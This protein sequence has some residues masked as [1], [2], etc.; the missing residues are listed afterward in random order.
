MATPVPTLSSAGWVVTPAQKADYLMAHFYEAMNNQS[1][2]FP[3]EVS[4][5]QYV[6]EKNA[7]DIPA[8]CQAIQQ[9][10]EKYLSRYYPNTTV[11]VSSDD[12]SGNTS[13]QVN[14]TIYISA[15]EAGETYA[16]TSLIQMANS[17]FVKAINLNNTGQS[18]AASVVQQITS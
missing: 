8:T 12:T 1:Y 14:L 11:Q 3:G 9:V 5:I 7:G 4:S 16:F 10:L 13:S 6:I 15:L 2:I 18:V 17:K